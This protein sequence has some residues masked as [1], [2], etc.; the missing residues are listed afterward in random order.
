[1][2]HLIPDFFEV[3]STDHVYQ[4]NSV[5]QDTEPICLFTLVT[6]RNGYKAAI[7]DFIMQDTT[8]GYTEINVL[9]VD[10]N[11]EHDLYEALSLRVYINRVEIVNPLELTIWQEEEKDLRRQ[12]E[13]IKQQ[14][15][16]LLFRKFV[17]Q[18]L[19]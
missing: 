7:T 11:V 16:I 18:L 15:R 17:N 1:M 4:V 14:Q 9:M 19:L 10:L 2:P 3:C 8:W 5:L 13:H 12:E 6:D